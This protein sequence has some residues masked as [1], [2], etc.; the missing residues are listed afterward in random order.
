MACSLPSTILFPSLISL[1][2]SATPIWLKEHVTTPLSLLPMRPDGVR[3]TITFVAKS[4]PQKPAENVEASG[5]SEKGPLLTLEVLNQ[6]SKVL[7]SVPSTISAKEYFANIAPQLLSLLEAQD[8]DTRRAAAF[9]ISHG[10]LSKRQFGHPTAIGWKCFA[11]PLLMAINPATASANDKDVLPTGVLHTLKILSAMLLEFPNP[12]LSKRLLSPII[13][14]LWAISCSSASNIAENDLAIG[15]LKHYVHAVA[16]LDGLLLIAS[17][18]MYE[19]KAQQLSK[20]TGT[21]TI[22]DTKQV[23]R[24]CSIF[25]NLVEVCH[26]SKEIGE[27]FALML[28]KSLQRP[29]MTFDGTASFDDVVREIVYSHIVQEMISKLSSRIVADASSSFLVIEEVLRSQ[30]SAIQDLARKQTTN[31][32]RSSLATI[33]QHDTDGVHDNHVLELEESLGICLPWLVVVLQQETSLDLKAITQQLASIQ[34]LLKTIQYIPMIQQFTKQSIRLAMSLISNAQTGERAVNNQKEAT[35]DTE[36]NLH[37]SAIKNLQATEPPIRVQGL[38]ELEGLILRG[39]PLVSISS[40]ALTTISLLQDQD[41]FVYLS[42]VKLLTFLA[43]KGPQSTLRIL[44][45]AYQDVTE[46]STLDVRL[47]IGEA[48]QTVFEE[49]G[50]S[51]PPKPVIT[52]VELLLHTINRRVSRSKACSAEESLPKVARPV[53]EPRDDDSDTDTESRERQEEKDVQMVLESWQGKSGAEDLRIR[54][55]ALTVLS[56]IFEHV[57]FSSVGVFVTPTLEL[58]SRIM[59][60]EKGQENAIIR[61]AAALTVLSILKGME[62]AGDTLSTPGSDTKDDVFLETIDNLFTIIASEDDDDIVRGHAE[63]V[64]Q[65]IRDWREDTF[66]RLIRGDAIKLELADGD[67][68]T[69][70]RGIDLD[71]DA[72]STK[73]QRGMRK[74]EEI[75]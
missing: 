49:I 32:T 20:N 73:P 62:R 8:P 16:S 28:K 72:E 17:N 65:A 53:E 27:F 5:G 71:V 68:N 34:T 1:L 13:L 41:S 7:S 26:T 3:Q 2:H 75:D 25:I 44:Q 42:A 63:N 21:D 55:S 24:R 30:I 12:G 46:Q 43:K 52:M 39:S 22:W 29:R 37:A 56:A 36:V 45:E 35:Q 9:T 60:S 54:M 33:V 58:V 48:L 11:Q 38:S 57:K 18:L 4:T 70:L 14:P 6:V 47:R 66:N 31:V 19:R 51:L 40:T 15:L 23:V 64:V 69:R 61:R 74:V 59:N 10:I 67:G 50:W